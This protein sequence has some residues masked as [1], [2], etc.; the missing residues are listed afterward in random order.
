MNDILDVSLL[1][2]Y[3]CYF[4]NTKILPKNEIIQ[5]SSEHISAIKNATRFI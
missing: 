4:K 5:L 2:L 1:A 3:P